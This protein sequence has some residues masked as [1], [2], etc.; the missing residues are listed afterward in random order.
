[1]EDHMV[2][3]SCGGPLGDAPEPICDACWCGGA[4]T[5]RHGHPFDACAQCDIGR[6]HDAY[7][8][9]ECADAQAEARQTIGEA[10]VR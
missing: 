9:R 7:A 2:C 10:V 8:D 3:Q 4:A 1:M 5:C 6:D